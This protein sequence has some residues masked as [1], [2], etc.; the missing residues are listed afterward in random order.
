MNWAPG[1]RAAIATTVCLVLTSAGG[2]AAAAAGSSVTHWGSFFA[3]NGAEDRL[4]SPTALELPGRVVEVAS[5]N[6]TQYALLANGSVYAWGLGNNGQ[7]G[8]G[9]TADSLTTPV[10]VHFPVGVKIAALPTDAMPYNTALAV[11][12][13][14]HAW[15][16]GLNQAGQL[17]L[18]NTAQYLIPIELPLSNVAA[19][20]GAGDHALYDSGGT[21]FGCG[22]N[23]YGDLGNGS[24]NPSSVPV[25]VQGLAAGQVRTLVASFNDSGAL[26]ADGDYLDWGY[27][28]QGQLGDGVIGVASAIPVA[29]KLPHRVTQVAQGGSFSNNGQTLVR[30]SDGTL[31]SWGADQ[32][33]QLG[34]HATTDQASPIAFSP[35]SGV[36]YARLATSGATSY[37]VSTSGDV[38]TWGSGSGGEIGDGG[39]A[40]PETP[41]LVGSGVSLISA[42][43]LDVVTG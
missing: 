30:L 25:E 10:R 16:W 40:N 37:A 38:Y 33:G 28:G 26:L 7:L 15:G 11:D 2:G 5:S 24:T 8:D 34:N 17:C 43:A 12:T 27:D 20:A 18:G 31:R 42:T 36:T 14:G 9:S 41:V 23:H 32:D 22:A 1:V 39:L 21:V 29:V 4:V 19:L 3:G 6:S 13:T 35:P